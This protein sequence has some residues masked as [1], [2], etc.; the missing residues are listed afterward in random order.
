MCRDELLRPVVVPAGVASNVHHQEP[1]PLHFE[2]LDI[3]MDLADICTVAIA[4]HSTKLFCCRDSVGD[5]QV[6]KITGMPNLVGISEKLLQFGVVMAMSVG[7]KTYKWHFKLL[8]V[9]QSLM[10]ILRL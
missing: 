10:T 3:W 9:N 2:K 7:K 1:E 6:T 8:L 4:V 5:C